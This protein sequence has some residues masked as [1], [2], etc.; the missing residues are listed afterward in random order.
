MHMRVCI[1]IS[2]RGS[3]MEA[4]IEGADNY[5]VEMVISN[6][7]DAPGLKVAKGLGVPCIARESLREIEYVLHKMRPDLVCMAGFMKILPAHLTDEYRV[8]NIHPSLLPKYPGLRAV[9]Q[10]LDDGAAYSGCTVHFADS[11]VDTG[12]IIAQDVVAVEPDDTPETLAARI[13]EKEHR[14]YVGS[15]RWYAGLS[16]VEEMPMVHSDAETIA[17]SIGTE[18]PTYVWRYDTGYMF[19]P[20]KPDTPTYVVAA[21]GDHPSLVCERMIRLAEPDGD[22]DRKGCL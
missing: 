7:P 13:L 1:L 10:A 5:T 19:G 2:G 4:L 11:G 21:P 22:R 8:M 9:K 3:N 16:D 15:V 6:K 17:S 14:L 18:R 20:E 12:K